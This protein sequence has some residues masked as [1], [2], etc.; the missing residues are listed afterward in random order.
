MT[1]AVVGS[2]SKIEKQ[3]A[4]YEK[5]DK[6]ISQQWDDFFSVNLSLQSRTWS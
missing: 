2:S 5:Q 4:S 3:E 1:M 6:Y